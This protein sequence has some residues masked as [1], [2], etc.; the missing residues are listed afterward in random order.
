[1]ER[2]NYKMMLTV[3]SLFIFA[4]MVVFAPE[5]TAE[6]PMAH[7]RWNAITI[8]VLMLTFWIFELL[9]IYVTAL[10]PLLL[11]VPLKVLNGDQLAM[12]YGDNLVFLFLGGFVLSLALEKYNVHKQ[13]AVRIIRIV[14]TKKWKLLFGF[15]IATAL[16]SM[17]ISN[18]ATALMML[19]MAVA[20]IDDLP[21]MTKSKFSIFLLLGIAYS[22]SVG[23]MATI[24]GSPPNGAMVKA[25]QQDEFGISVGFMDWM[26]VGFPL[27]MIMLLAVFGFFVLLLGKE[28]NE[29]IEEI[30]IEKFKWDINQKRVI[31]LFILVVLLWSFKSPIAY[32][33]GI[34][35][36]IEVPAILGAILMFAISGAKNKKLLE[37]KDT[38]KLPW[39]ILLL[40]GGGLALAEMLRVNGV[41]DELATLFYKFEGVE[42]FLILLVLIALA[43]YGTEV[44][45]NL[46]LVTVLVPVV[47]IFA[48]NTEYSILQL[49]MP[50]TL[51]ASCAFMLPISTPP[52]AIVF[53]SGKLRINQMAK[54]GFVL[55]LIGVLLVSV[56]SLWF[57]K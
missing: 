26:A 36:P 55:N 41:I 48:Q 25:L 19:P 22:A 20:V 2:I 47:A 5:N 28:R 49:C 21:K 8:G 27:S 39:G 51:A 54:I 24:V 16:L 40:F 53:S 33:T 45:S 34:K 30:N 57:I 12:S 35:Y 50:V 17:W 1:M 7:N 6:D 4:T 42:T 43:I 23:G 52:N 56:F 18:T 15:M 44:M 3:A 31:G 11:A 46:A 9:P 13:I 32:W 37:W 29:D 10:F 14:G 38:T